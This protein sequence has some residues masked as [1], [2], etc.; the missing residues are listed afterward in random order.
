MLTIVVTRGHNH[1]LN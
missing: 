1:A